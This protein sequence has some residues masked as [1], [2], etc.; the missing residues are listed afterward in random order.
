MS[1]ALAN[2]LSAY[3]GRRSLTD[4]LLEGKFGTAFNYQTYLEFTATCMEAVVEAD[5]DARG[6]FSL[7]ADRMHLRFLHAVNQREKLIFC[8]GQKRTFSRIRVLDCA[9]C[10]TL[11]RG[12]EYLPHVSVH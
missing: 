5:R 8:I 7:P 11:L 10:Y 9:L 2:Q 3:R 1:H 12:S 4:D 6:Y